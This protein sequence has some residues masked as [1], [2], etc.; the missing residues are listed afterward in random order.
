MVVR[1]E[2]HHIPQTAFVEFWASLHFAGNS[3]VLRGKE[4]GAGG[5]ER[6]A[7][8]K[9]ERNVSRYLLLF[10][11]MQVKTPFCLHVNFEKVAKFGR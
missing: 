1:E 11:R 9:K 6:R 2:V 4:Q 8:G 5:K 3:A 10:D 7:G